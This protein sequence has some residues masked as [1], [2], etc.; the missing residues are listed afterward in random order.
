[1]QEA[2]RGQTLGGVRRRVGRNDPVVEPGGPP[3]LLPAT[4]PHRVDAGRGAQVQ[5]LPLTYMQR[6]PVA[7]RGDLQRANHLIFGKSPTGGA[8]AELAVLRVDAVTL[9][10]DRTDVLVGAGLDTSDVHPPP[11]A[12]DTRLA[13]VASETGLG[14]VP[15]DVTVRAGDRVGEEPLDLVGSVTT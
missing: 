13:V 3:S 5:R 11:A 8:A 6:P 1:M 4:E 15:V 9:V 14:P 10:A 2:Q 12:R 7:H